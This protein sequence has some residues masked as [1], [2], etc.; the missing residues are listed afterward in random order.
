MRVLSGFLSGTTA[1]FL[2]LSPALAEE[3]YPPGGVRTEITPP[4]TAPARAA[5]S[6]VEILTGQPAMGRGRVP[7][8]ACPDTGEGN[9]GAFAVWFAQWSQPDAFGYVMYPT[10][11]AFKS[12]QHTLGAGESRS[13]FIGDAYVEKFAWCMFPSEG[14]VGEDDVVV[15]FTVFSTDPEKCGDEPTPCEEYTTEPSPKLNDLH[16]SH[17]VGQPNEYLIDVSGPETGEVT[18]FIGGRLG[19][20]LGLAT[21]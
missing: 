5:G 3:A 8:D 15:T 7:F 9:F 14:D 13:F 11:P 1:L 10:G 12:E 2:A 6:V 18:F 17:Y 20:T 21:N 4:D 19:T 16:T